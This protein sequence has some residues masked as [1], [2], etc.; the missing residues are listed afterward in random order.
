M[1]AIKLKKYAQLLEGELK[2]NLGKSRDIDWL[3]QYPILLKALEDAKKGRIDEP[4]TLGLNRWIFESDI[5][6]FAALSTRLAQF[7]NLLR[8]WE[9]STETD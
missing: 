1:D 4:R 9:L 6:S 7:E 3:A 5:Q 8:G 2:L